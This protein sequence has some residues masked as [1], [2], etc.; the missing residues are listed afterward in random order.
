MEVDMAKHVEFGKDLGLIAQLV[1]RGCAAGIGHYEFW[2]PL[3]SSKT[4]MMEVMSFLDN[5]T[6][7]SVAQMAIERAPW[8]RRSAM[9]EP[10]REPDVQTLAD[11]IRNARAFDIGKKQWQSLAE[12]IELFRAMVEY[13]QFAPPFSVMVEVEYGTPP[14]YKHSHNPCFAATSRTGREQ[15]EMSIYDVPSRGGTLAEVEMYVLGRGWRF[16]DQ[17]E[18]YWFGQRTKKGIRPWALIGDVPIYGPGTMHSNDPVCYSF[19][20]LW[21]LRGNE[22]LDLSA[23]VKLGQCSTGCGKILVVK[24]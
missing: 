16:A 1:Q 6:P 19:P 2:G 10:A 8:L 12:N 22:E 21:M 14:P 15:H 3:N 13:L 20:R 7:E 4:L 18:L 17:N 23:C 9:S 24:D 5:A 11:V